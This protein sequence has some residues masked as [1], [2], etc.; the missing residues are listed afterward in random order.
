MQ[1]DLRS[2]VERPPEWATLAGATPDYVVSVRWLET[3]APLLPGEPR[4]LIATVDGRAQIGLHTRWLRSPPG[5]PRYDIAAVLRGDIPSP[6]R[7]RC[8]EPIPIDALYPSLLVVLPGYV[9]AAAGSGA[10]DQ[11]VLQGTLSAVEVWAAARGARSVSFLYVPQRQEPLRRALIEYGA[12]AVPLYPTCVL[13]LTF[14][15]VEEFHHQLPKA[16]RRDIARLRRRLTESDIAVGEAE[17]AQVRDE[18]L[19][20]RLGL[21]RKYG[22]EADATVQSSVIDRMLALYEPQDVVVAVARRKDGLAGFSLGLRHEDT[23]RLLWCGQRPDAYGA[24]FVTCFYESVRAALARGVTRIDYGIMKWD[25][26]MSFGCRLE[27]LT[28]HLLTIAPN[29]E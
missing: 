26:K 12:Q 19:D 3:M 23:L 5:E 28:G 9:C 11:P 4:W 18:V 24:Y 20:L 22:S 7:H 16:R 10:A 2:T 25:L 21:L 13:P 27:Q 1:I 6:E 17:L 29:A 15:S 8:S 14:D